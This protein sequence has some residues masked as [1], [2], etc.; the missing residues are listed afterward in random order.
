MGV[1]V[2]NFASSTLDRASGAQIIDGSLKFDASAYLT[3]TPSTVGN[4]NTWTWSGWVKRSDLTTSGNALFAAYDSS[5]A[6]DVIRFDR[7]ASGAELNLQS[8]Q[9]SNLS[10]IHI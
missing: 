1:I 4:R 3:R 5:T 9:G 7:S 10:L 2:P 8:Q 6:R